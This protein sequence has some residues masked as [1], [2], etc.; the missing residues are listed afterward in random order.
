MDKKT[1]KREIERETDWIT[2]IS[3][4]EQKQQS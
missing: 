1:N 4:L 3:R 2:R